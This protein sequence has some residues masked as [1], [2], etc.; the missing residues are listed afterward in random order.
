[1]GTEMADVIQCPGCHSPIDVARPTDV[2]WQIV[3][4]RTEETSPVPSSIP[5]Q[6]RD[7]IT[8]TVG[9]AIVHQCILCV[10]GDWR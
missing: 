4:D 2:D 10:D 7:R 8:I 9:R 5:T 6:G 3:R 1:M